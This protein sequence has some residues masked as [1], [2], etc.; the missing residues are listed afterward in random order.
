M[1][2]SKCDTVT[3]FQ[4][5]EKYIYKVESSNIGTRLLSSVTFKSWSLY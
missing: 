5:N 1:V 4:N 2:L 3:N